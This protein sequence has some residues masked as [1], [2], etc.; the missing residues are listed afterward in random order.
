MTM[1]QTVQIILKN[2]AFLAPIVIAIS[3]SSC[4]T[5]Y[6]INRAK[7]STDVFTCSI[8]KGLGLDARIGPLTLGLSKKS[9][10]MGLRAGQF[11]SFEVDK[12]NVSGNFVYM[13][14]EVF[15]P[16][17]PLIR[18]RKK[19]YFAMGI[20]GISF[21]ADNFGNPRWYYVTNIEASFAILYGLRIGFNWGEC[22]DFILGLAGIDLFDDDLIPEKNVES[23][24]S[25]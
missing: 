16:D 17:D 21:A 22:V 6:W 20:A 2:G 1:N 4:Q 25:G 13:N 3:L 10:L 18:R 23:P 15:I 12:R 19:D 7:D 9:D 11:G 5:N 24:G 14:A 8:T